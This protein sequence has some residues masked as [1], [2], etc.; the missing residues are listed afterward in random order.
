MFHCLP[1]VKEKR[2][3]K[4]Q[5]FSSNSGHNWEAKMES[6]HTFLRFCCWNPSLSNRRGLLRYIHIFYVFNA[7]YMS[8]KQNRT[9]QNRTGYMLTSKAGTHKLHLN[10]II[11]TLHTAAN[12]Q[13]WKKSPSDLCKLC[14]GRKIKN[15]ILKIFNVGLNTGRWEWRHD[16]IPNYIASS[17]NTNKFTAFSD[18]EGHQA[19]DGG[20]I[21]LRYASLARGQ[22]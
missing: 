11:D 5:P 18:F 21:L 12:L 19:A 1:N 2:R 3:K 7:N 4:R 9:E 22:I 6:G 16:T 13:R 17:V 20:T 8:S 10:G 15:H 14:R